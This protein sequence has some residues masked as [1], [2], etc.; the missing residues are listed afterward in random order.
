MCGDFIPFPLPYSS[1]VPKLGKHDDGDLR[2]GY[3]A[4][5]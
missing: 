1:G 5:A 4:R 2:E 3:Q